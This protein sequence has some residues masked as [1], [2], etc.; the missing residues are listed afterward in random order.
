MSVCL[1]GKVQADRRYQGATGQGRTGTSR[2]TKPLCG[3]EETSKSISSLNC[4]LQFITVSFPHSC[5]KGTH[6]VESSL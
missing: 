2:S 5:P 4:S 6:S 3:S 1:G